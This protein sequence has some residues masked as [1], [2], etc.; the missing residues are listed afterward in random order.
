MAQTVFH[1]APADSARA[2]C[3]FTHGR[4]QSPEEMIETVLARVDA[5]EVRFAL[6]RAPRDAWYDARAVDPL[7][8]ATRAQLDAAL[9][10]LRQT[11]TDTRAACPGLP[12]VVA[13]FSQ[14]ACLSAEY[15]LRGGMA[16]A[17][18]LLTGCRVGTAGDHPP[19]P[20]LGAMPVYASNGDTDP[21]IAPMPWAQMAGALA[22][23]GAR[24]R[25]DI[26]PG[27]AHE[28][29]E[30]EC[31]TFSAMLDALSLK[32]PLWEGR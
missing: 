18:V 25:C 14:G 24:L 32:Q 28:V 3:V 22:Q 4:G 20:A 1:G 10:Q 17:A 7:T 29:S 27:R 21:W 26:L 16:D 12:L 19:L 11:I 8:E 23:A 31:A 5:P 2:V 15:L 30:T 13:G 9:D 6:P